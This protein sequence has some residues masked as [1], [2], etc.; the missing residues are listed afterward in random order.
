MGFLTVAK[1]WV[2]RIWRVEL[3]TRW[4]GGEDGTANIQ[5]KQLAART[6]YLKDFADEVEEA[7]ESET[8]LLDRIKKTGVEPMKILAK[9]DFIS[10]T[11][12]AAS[13]ANVDVTSGGLMTM[14]GIV[15]RVGDL[16][17]LKDQ[18]NKKQNGFWQVQ[19]GAWNRFPNFTD[20][21]CF[22]YKFIFIKKGTANAGK[23]FFLDKDV[24]VID[25]DD[26]EFKESLFSPKRLPNKVLLHDPEGKTYFDSLRY[27]AMLSK[28]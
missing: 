25:T 1:Q 17:F 10:D 24:Y 26:L 15:L 20:N 9:F 18:T 6:E 2:E 3:D 19:T 11:P 28:G 4:A 7:R 16:V 27:M 8:S 14:D 22:T 23:V 13:T 5:A 21:D 12:V